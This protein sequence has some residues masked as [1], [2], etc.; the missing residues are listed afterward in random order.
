ML[1]NTNP[2]MFPTRICGLFRGEGLEIDDYFDGMILS[3]RERVCKP[4]PE[5]FNRLLNRYS[6][7][8]ERTLFLDDSAHNCGAA[9]DAGI[10]SAL[11]PPGTDF[12]DILTHIE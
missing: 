12:M 3:Y 11:V 6:L 9:E 2:V 1:S 5:I 7:N 8:P 10:R 4:S